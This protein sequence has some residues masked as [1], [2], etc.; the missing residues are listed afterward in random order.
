MRP[1]S[2]S[3]YI[4]DTEAKER[5]HTVEIERSANRVAPTPHRDSGAV[6]DPDTAASDARRSLGR[7]RVR[8]VRGMVFDYGAPRRWFSVSI[9]DGPVEMVMVGGLLLHGQMMC[10][11][12]GIG[13]CHHTHAVIES[14]ALNEDSAPVGAEA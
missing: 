3:E 6:S 5:R 1:R 11:D 7:Y 10:G 12:H 2:I 4:R 9:D 13:A 14:E 8:E